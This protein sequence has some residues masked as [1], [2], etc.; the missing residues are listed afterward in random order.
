MAKITQ[1]MID[2]MLP[3]SWCE[4]QNKTGRT[5]IIKAFRHEFVVNCRTCCESWSQEN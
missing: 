5:E 3:C 2:S 1:K 4:S